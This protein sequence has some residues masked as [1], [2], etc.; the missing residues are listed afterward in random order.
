MVMH[1]LQ[2]SYHYFILTCQVSPKRYQFSIWSQPSADPD[3]WREAPRSAEDHKVEHGRIHTLD[4]LIA[5]Y[6]FGLCNTSFIIRHTRWSRNACILA[7]DSA[8]QASHAT[9]PW[10]GCLSQISLMGMGSGPIS[11][12]SYRWLDKSAIGELHD[13]CM[14]EWEHSWRGSGA[15]FG[16]NWGPE[17]SLCLASSFSWWTHFETLDDLC[18]VFWQTLKA[19]S[20]RTWREVRGKLASY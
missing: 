13:L 5:R 9:T 14:S 12:D 1:M 18:L 20:S 7:L 6:A 11:L 19:S 17:W 2:L 10:V 4:A 3:R 15:N 8:F 16:M